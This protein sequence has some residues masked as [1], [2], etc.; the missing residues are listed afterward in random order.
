MNKYYLFIYHSRLLIFLSC[1]TPIL[2]F[3]GSE[4]PLY[5]VCVLCC[6]ISYSALF[7]FGLLC[8]MDFAFIPS[9]LCNSRY[10]HWVSF[11]ETLTW[12]PYSFVV[13]TISDPATAFSFFPYMYHF[14][15]VYI[16]FCLSTQCLEALLQHIKLAF[17]F[18]PW[19]SLHYPSHLLLH[20]SFPHPHRTCPFPI[21]FFFSF[22]FC[23]S[24]FKYAR[25]NKIE[26]C[27]SLEEV[28]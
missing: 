4:V 14:V 6:N 26:I 18:T 27:L 7:H 8:L 22:L 25:E 23:F 5:T 10:G 24:G 21:F 20:C 12:R 9:V 1:P 11:S 28:S 13:I 3:P 19:K 17:V 15:L 16:S 2:S